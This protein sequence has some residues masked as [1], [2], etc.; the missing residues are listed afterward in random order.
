MTA[1]TRF[2][3]DSAASERSPTDPVSHHATVFMAMV[4]TAAAIESQAKRVSLC[5]VEDME[6][7]FC[8]GRGS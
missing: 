7:Y 6:G 4:V 8:R 5:A 2:T 1:A 3:T